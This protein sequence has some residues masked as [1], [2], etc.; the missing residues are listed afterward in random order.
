MK[1]GHIGTPVKDIKASKALY[2]AIIGHVGREFI[3]GGETSVRCG[4]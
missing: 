2:D 3:D 4:V 1:L